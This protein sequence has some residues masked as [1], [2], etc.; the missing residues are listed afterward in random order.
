MKILIILILVKF[1]TETDN[2]QK[3]RPVMD[4]TPLKKN[5]DGPREDLY[6]QI[7]TKIRQDENTF[8]H[9]STIKGNVRYFG[10]TPFE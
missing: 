2:L 4:N 5:T 6:H 1:V 9:F 3:T 8:I 10:S 7:F